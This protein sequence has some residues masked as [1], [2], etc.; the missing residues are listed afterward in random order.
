VPAVGDAAAVEHGRVVAI[1]EP[2]SFN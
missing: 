1:V 2:E